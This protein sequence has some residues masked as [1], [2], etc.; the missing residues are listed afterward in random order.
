ML[1]YFEIS[2]ARGQ[3]SCEYHVSC[4]LFWFDM[5]QY[6]EISMARGQMSCVY[7]VSRSLFWFDMLQYFETSS[8]TGQMG[9]ACI[10]SHVD[11]FGW[12]V[13]HTLRWV[14]PRGGGVLAEYGDSQKNLKQSWLLA[15]WKKIPIARIMSYTDFS[16]WT[17]CCTLEARI[18]C[19]LECLTRDQKVACSNPGRSGGKF[20]FSRVNFMCWLWSTFHACDTTVAHKIP[21]SF[22]QKCRWQV[23]PKH[24]RS[25]SGLTMPLL[26]HSVGTYQE[27]S[28][29]ANHQGTLSHSWLSLLSH[30]GLILA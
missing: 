24:S 30:C 4:S 9:G 8:S 12:T 26:G 22:C 5:L 11:F 16:G 6:F 3:M 19:W 28:S 23:T 2:M 18:A 15:F 27:T 7:Y 29:H 10:T 1:Q 13:C 21:W 25:Q 17:E 20:F 14:Q